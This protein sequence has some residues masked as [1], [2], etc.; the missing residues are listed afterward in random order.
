MQSRAFSDKIEGEED[1]RS[2]RVVQNKD[3]EV[4]GMKHSRLWYTPFLGMAVAMLLPFAAFSQERGWVTEDGNVRFVDKEGSYAVNQWKTLQGKSFYLDGDGNLTRN[5]W[6]DETWYVGEDGIMQ[7]ETWRYEDGT[8]EMAEGWYYLGRDGKAEK[9]DWKTIGEKRYCFNEN[10]QMRSGWYYE[11]GDIYYLGGKEEGIPVS[12]WQYLESAEG[13]AEEGSISADL[14]PEEKGGSWYYFQTNGKAKRASGKDYEE[15]DIDGKKYYFDED[16]KMLTGWHCIR[17][18]AAA[19]DGTG[20]SRF[21]YLGGKDQGL[22]RNQ[23]LETETLPWKSADWEKAKGSTAPRKNVTETAQTKKTGPRRFYLESNGS[24]A[25]LSA[26]AVTMKDA[27]KKIDGAYYFFDSYGSMQTGLIK[28]TSSEGTQ[29]AYFG[30]AGGDGK[31]RTGRINEVSD[32][33][34]A[35]RTFCFGSSGSLKGTGYNGEKDGFL[36]ADGL[37]L[38]A[39]KGSGYAPFE[40]AG[41]IWLV[42]EAGQVQK[43]EKEYQAS[44]GRTYLIQDGIVWKMPMSYDLAKDTMEKQ[45]VMEESPIVSVAWNLV[46]NR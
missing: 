24:P 33:N 38:K 21:V 15:T 18:Q 32:R 31:M 7:K 34:G 11:N 40:A 46:Y 25:F 29:T 4:R 41:R 20:I 45:K 1:K 5:A 14:A 28:M 12:G 3:Q 19:G 8:G 23:W 42:N 16:G 37:L 35:V 39:E 36:Y 43:E 2:K 44:E 26:D 9:N 27:M 22:L 17:E 13:R 10:G 6:I 30:E